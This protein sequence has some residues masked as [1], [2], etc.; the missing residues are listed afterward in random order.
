MGLSIRSGMSSR[1]GVADAGQ[2]PCCEHPAGKVCPHH[3]TRQKPVEPCGG[4][5]GHCGQLVVSEGVQTANVIP[6]AVQIGVYATLR[7]LSAESPIDG[8]RLPA[9][10]LYDLFTSNRP[11][12]LFS[13]H[14][15]LT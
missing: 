13:L 3:R 4:G 10:D 15:A 14:C 6:I 2:M 9:S 8:S 5:C 1:L 11:T 7:D 12:T